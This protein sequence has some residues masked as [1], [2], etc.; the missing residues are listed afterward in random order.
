L[1]FIG[2]ERLTSIGQGI[3][4]PLVRFWINFYQTNLGGGFAISFAGMKKP[5]KNSPKKTSEAPSMGAEGSMAGEY[6]HILAAELEVN[7]DFGSELG[8]AD[9]QTP[10]QDL[11][12]PE[13]ESL[14][15][16]A[17]VEPEEAPGWNPIALDGPL[18]LPHA[19]EALVFASEKPLDARQIASLL[20]SLWPEPVSTGEVQGVLDQLVLEWGQRPG[21]FELV[22]TGG[23]YCYLTRSAFL[24]LVQK[25]V[26]EQS[27]RKLSVASLE[28][29]AI[30]AYKQPVS[31]SEVEQIRGVNCDFSIQ[32]LL[33]KKLI[34]ISG[35]GDGPGRPTLYSTSELFMD[36]FG[37]NS[38]K[39]LP[40]L[41][42]LEQ[43]ENRIGGEDEDAFETHVM[44]LHAPSDEHA[45]SE[46]N[47]ALLET[48]LSVTDDAEASENQTP[49][50]S[51]DADETYS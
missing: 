28:T 21:G 42:D 6:A 27:K 10:G 38:I 46:T 25:A 26:L 44:A 13:S 48:E 32:K 31:K 9:V 24:P 12:V 50:D 3:G 30:V 1:N 16:S 47:E 35:K 41:K 29:L 23:G 51:R 2:K 15:P 4:G 7:P 37:I 8:D 33:E 39:Q 45:S 14:V 22:Q 40:Q 36:Y 43:E 17:P 11:E 18:E 5:V 19:V 34:R 49:T 20:A